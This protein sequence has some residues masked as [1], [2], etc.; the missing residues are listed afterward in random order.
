LEDRDFRHLEESGKEWFSS[1]ALETRNA[2]DTCWARCCARHF[3]KQVQIAWKSILFLKV[4]YISQIP[5]NMR[6]KESR[7]QLNQTPIAKQKIFNKTI[8]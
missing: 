8:S 1:E 5:L 2:G 6:L 7:L 4:I 3:T